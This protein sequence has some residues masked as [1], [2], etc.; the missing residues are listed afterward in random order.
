MHSEWSMK[1]YRKI[2]SSHTKTG[3]IG[4]SKMFIDTIEDLS[5]IWNLA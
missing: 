3:A 1:K 2:I 4:I 5:A